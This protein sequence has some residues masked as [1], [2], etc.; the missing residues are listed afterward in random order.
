MPFS[1]GPRIVGSVRMADLL[2]MPGTY[3]ARQEEQGV[4]F[5]EREPALG[6]A[7]ASNI[8]TCPH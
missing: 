7:L 1:M 3:G 8:N 2:S 5:S 6:E 4:T